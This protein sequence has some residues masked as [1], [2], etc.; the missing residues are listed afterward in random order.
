MCHIVAD[1]CMECASVNL[2][3]MCCPSSSGAARTV[4]S[5]YP[6]ASTC[7]RQQPAWWRPRRSTPACVW[8][9]SQRPVR[10]P[11]RVHVHVT[12]I[13]GVIVHRQSIS[14]LSRSLHVTREAF[15][16]C[17]CAYMSHRC[18]V[19]AWLSRSVHVTREVFDSYG[20][21]FNTRANQYRKG[22]DADAAAEEGIWLIA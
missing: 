21:M 10:C 8:S 1:A 13:A 14:C 20:V 4:G 22:A 3:C 7:P 11:T 5:S 2:T 19:V 6:T 16:P 15:D 9:L 17:P 18:G 12:R